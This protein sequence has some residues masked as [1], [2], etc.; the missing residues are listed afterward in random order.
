[1]L[2]VLTT[3]MAMFCVI[4]LAYLFI[5]GPWTIASFGW[6]VSMN[7]A[8]EAIPQTV[9]VC[10][11]A[12]ALSP[13]TVRAYR[14]HSSFAFYLFAALFLAILAM[15]PY[16][17]VMGTSITTYSPYLGFMHLPGIDGLRVPARFWMLVL[18][19]LTTVLGVGYSRF[20]R[21]GTRCSRHVLL[22]L[23]AGILIDGWVTFPTVEAPARS[24]VLDNRVNGPLLELPLNE[25]RADAAAMF[26]MFHHGQAVVNGYSGYAAPH[27]SALAY[28]LGHSRERLLHELGSLGVRYVRIDRANQTSPHYESLVASSPIFRLV[29]ETGRE[30]LYEL[31]GVLVADPP[32]VLKGRSIPLTAVTASANPHLAAFSAD[33]DFDTVWSSGPQSVGQELLLDL[34]LSQPLFAV[35]M[36]LGRHP[37]DFPRILEIELSVSGTEWELIRDGPTDYETVRASLRDPE[38]TPITFV[39]GNHTARYVRLRQ[40]GED[41]AVSWSVAEIDVVAPVS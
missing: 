24:V 19:C 22:A 6:D 34:G 10:V 12:L 32:V 4:G 15:G 7:R 26:R 35:V 3:T 25:S 17:S 2:R 40:M 29:S 28:G 39:L 27:Y 31:R 1:M 20:V 21:A 23:S 16:P 37:M 18:V 11:I 8:G 36:Y 5:I 14:Y 38:T 13:A 33:D 9:L 41:Q 30:S